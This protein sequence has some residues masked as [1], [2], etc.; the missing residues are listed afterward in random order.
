MAADAAR[1]L[2]ELMGLN[3]NS[4]PGDTKR[5]HWSDR[6]VRVAGMV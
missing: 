3:R 4:G 1:L 2:D 6:E 5:V